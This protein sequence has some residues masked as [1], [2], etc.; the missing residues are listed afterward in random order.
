M[1]G[2]NAVTVEGVVIDVFAEG[3]VAWSW[4]TG[5]SRWFFARQ[6]SRQVQLD[7]G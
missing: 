4:R 2:E 3:P 6:G 7:V 5:M 1:S